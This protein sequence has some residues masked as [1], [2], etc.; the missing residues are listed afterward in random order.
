[1]ASSS[2][3]TLDDIPSQVAALLPYDDS[4]AP[5]RD[6]PMDESMEV[7]DLNQAPEF[8]EIKICDTSHSPH[9]PLWDQEDYNELVNELD[10]DW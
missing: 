10:P 9:C 8:K 1:V 7:L 6:I 2:S 4:G 5:A 3:I